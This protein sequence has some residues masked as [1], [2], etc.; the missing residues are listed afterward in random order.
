MTVGMGRPT[1]MT[2]G[3][4][5]TAETLEVIFNPS[6]LDPQFEVLYQR[7]APPG[8]PHQILQYQGTSNVSIPMTLY[9]DA[10]DQNDTEIVDRINDFQ[11]FLMSLGYPDESADSVLSGAPPSVLV[12]WPNVVS[13]VA[14]LTGRVSFKYMTIGPFGYVLRYT[15]Q[16]TFEE[17]REVRLT[18]QDVR[19]SGMVRANLPRLGGSET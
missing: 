4:M 11:R 5:N 1:R 18:S 6:E 10:Y 12:V 7:V 14:K 17:F 19:A 15:A 13:F 3:N 16:V 8:L 9:A 2:L